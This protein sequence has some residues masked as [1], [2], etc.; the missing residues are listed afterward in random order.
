MKNLVTVLLSDAVKQ[1]LDELVREQRS[2]NEEVIA[3]AIVKA[4]E[5]QAK[6]VNTH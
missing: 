6:E 3:L 1:K 4:Y 2:T 5:L